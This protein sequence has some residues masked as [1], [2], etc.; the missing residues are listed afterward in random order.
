MTDLSG[1]HLSIKQ[2]IEKTTAEQFLG[3]YNRRFGTDF[4]ISQLG[5]TPDVECKDQGS[6]KKLYLE[7]TLL[8]DWEGEIQERLNEQAS[9]NTTPKLANHVASFENDT[10]PT[11]KERLVN[12]ISSYYGP[13][14]ALV[15]RQVSVLWSA[16][17]WKLHVGKIISEV[18]E[19]KKE[20]YGAGIWILCTKT[21]GLLGEDELF[22]LS[23]EPGQKKIDMSL[24]H[25]KIGPVT[26]KV[27]WA[28]SIST[29]FSDFVTHD[30]IEIVR[31][32]SPHGCGEA[33]LIA[34]PKEEPELVRQKAMEFYHNQMI[35]YCR[36]G[37][38]KFSHTASE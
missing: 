12:K 8:Q 34:F 24:L 33:I 7:I 18:L 4:K 38:G 26:A 1:T 3:V 5:D 17:D 27:A 10:L 9:A 25:T 15:I 13:D 16:E 30:G 23:D 22:S 2:Q 31:V 35:Y 6:G 19:G 20:N 21:I 14:T 11:L 36:C 37:R 29:E 28:G 32:E